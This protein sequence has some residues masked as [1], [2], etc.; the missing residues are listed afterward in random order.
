[1]RSKALS[2]C[3]ASTIFL[4]KTVPFHAVC[5]ARQEW[6]GRSYDVLARNCCAFCNEV[7]HKPLPLPC[8]ST[9]FL[10]KTLPFH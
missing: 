1:M 4:S 7:S 6:F 9:V 5:S 10:S 2:F 3:C 8:V